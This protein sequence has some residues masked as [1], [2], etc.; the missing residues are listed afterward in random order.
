MHGF[1]IVALA[2]GLAAAPAGADTVLAAGEAERVMVMEFEVKDQGVNRADDAEVASVAERATRLF[3]EKVE[4]D[5]RLTLVPAESVAAD[6]AAS[7]GSGPR[8]CRTTS[9]TGEAARRAGASR[10]VRGRYVKVSNLIRYLTVELVDPSTGEVVRSATAEV[11]GQRDVVLPRA[12]AALY[13]SLYPRAGEP[14]AR[15]GS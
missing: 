13:E 8:P 15:P 11:K 1:T 3:R 14:G 5:A 10:V 7:A 12:V 9:C 6:A 2:A 4:G